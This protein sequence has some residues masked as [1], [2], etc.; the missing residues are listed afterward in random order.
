MGL[1]CE[2]RPAFAFLYRAVLAGGLIEHELDHVFLG[3]SDSDP[4]PDPAEVAGWRWMAWSQLAAD[5]ERHP[6]LHSAWLPIAFRELER[7]GLVPP[8]A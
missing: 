3:R 1:E 6:E 8:P 7:R 5:L 4:R 2:L